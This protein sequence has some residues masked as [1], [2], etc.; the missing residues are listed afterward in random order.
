MTN[1]L[2]RAWVSATAIGILSILSA[3]TDSGGGNTSVAF[4][5]TTTTPTTTPPSANTPTYTAGVFEPA[6]NFKDRCQVVRTGVDIEG[7]PFTDMVGSTL[8][9]NFWLRSWTDETYLWNNE[10]ADRN[11]G[12]FATPVSYFNVLKTTATTPSGNPKDQFHFSQL[13]EDFLAARNSTPR[14]DYGAVLVDFSNTLPRDIRIVYTEPGSP[15]AQIVLGEA[16][17]I[18]GTK[19]LEVDGVDLLNANT[20]AEVDILN[21][22]LFPENAGETHSFLVQDPG[23]LPRAIMMT[24]AN[25]AAQPVNRTSII[26][27]ASGDVGY[28]LLNTFSPFSTEQDIANAITAMKTAGVTDLVLDLR[29]NGGGLL[30]IAAQL[31]YMIAGDAQTT[32]KTYELLQFNADAGNLNPITG[33]TNQPLPFFNT[34][35]GFSLA[36]GTPLDTL[37]LNRIYILATESTCSASESLINSLRGINVEVILFGDTT[38]GKPYGFFPTDNCGQ[39]YF[40]IQF[41]GVNDKNFGDYPD[42]FTPN[43]SSDAFAIKTPGCT[44]VDDFD[45]ELGDPTERMLATALYYRENGACPSPPLPKPAVTSSAKTQEAKPKPTYLNLSRGVMDENRDMTMPN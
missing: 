14:A 8:E 33:M 40:T 6:S 1:R 23:G 18:R 38:C 44:V 3:C 31:G 2:G 21:N 27:T 10:V 5:T 42:G 20:Q 7:N 36:D 34:G 35:L 28:I 26:N 11:P 22:G 9:E 12:G 19:I 32:G 43:D 41:R 15:A 4:T 39:T 30:A 29:Y 24:S 45:T 37:D 25:I 16:N 13:T 17:L